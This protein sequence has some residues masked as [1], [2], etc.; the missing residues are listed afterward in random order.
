MPSAAD[1]VPRAFV[2]STV[3]FENGSA[4]YHIRPRSVFDR[5]GSHER[6]HFNRFGQHPRLVE[7]FD[8]SAFA[9]QSVRAVFLFGVDTTLDN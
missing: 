9:G 5:I 8:N 2:L 6:K 4:Y 7:R 1:R 3:I